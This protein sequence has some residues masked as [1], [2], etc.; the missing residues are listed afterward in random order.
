MVDRFPIQLAKTTLID[1][2][3][4]SFIE[5]VHSKNL[6]KSRRPGEEIHFWGSLGPPNALS[7]KR[8]IV[9]CVLGSCKK[10]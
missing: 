7:R 2:D 8:G 6:L 1:H 5:V 4:L 9:F 3:K 10:I